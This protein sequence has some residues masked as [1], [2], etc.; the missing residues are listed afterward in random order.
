M[1]QQ[2]N[3]LISIAGTIRRCLV[4]ILAYN[5]RVSFLC[6]VF[7]VVV[8]II[9]LKQISM[10]PST[11][12]TRDAIRS[13]EPSCAVSEEAIRSSSYLFRSTVNV[14]DR[15]KQLRLLLLRSSSSVIYVNASVL[16]FDPC[17]KNYHHSTTTTNFIPL[18]PQS[19]VS[20]PTVCR[21]SY[22]DTLCGVACRRAIAVR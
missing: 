13:H 6:F 10:Y 18:R 3:E 15:L 20:R 5:Q 22:S 14:I 12:E 17:G 16:R 7:S 9:S 2:R 21:E 11:Q 1:S 8:R 4:K 19:P